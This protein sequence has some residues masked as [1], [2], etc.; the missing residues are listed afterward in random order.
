VSGSHSTSSTLMRI[1]NDLL[2][3]SEEK[4]V[5][6]LLLL[7]LF[8][9]FDS[10][11]HQ[12]LCVKLSNNMDLRLYSA[13]AFIRSYLRQRMQ[14]VNGSSSECLPVGTGVVQ[15]SV[16]GP[17]LIMTLST[18]YHSAATICTSTVCNSISVTVLLTFP[19]V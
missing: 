13:I 7:D 14:C 15:G 18:K 19:I 11:Y 1:T 3:A 4:Y 5:S 9:A 10:V 17:L 2:I 6:V 8:K 16:L 12:L